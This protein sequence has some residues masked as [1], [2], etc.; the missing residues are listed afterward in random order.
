M[1]VSASPPSP[2]LPVDKVKAGVGGG[3]VLVLHVPHLPALL[4][5]AL[6]VDVHADPFPQPGDVFV[7]IIIITTS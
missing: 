1:T 7:P 3:G 6:P 4:L 5:P 2:V